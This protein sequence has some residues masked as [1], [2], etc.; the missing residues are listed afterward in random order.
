VEIKEKKRYP[1]LVILPWRAL[2]DESTI[3]RGNISVIRILEGNE[4]KIQTQEVDST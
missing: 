4:R 1:E 3:V 2:L